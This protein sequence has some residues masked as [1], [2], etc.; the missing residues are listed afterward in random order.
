MDEYKK[1]DFNFGIAIY[2]P[3][4]VRT[5]AF[6]LTNEIESRVPLTFRLDE[7]HL[8]HITLFQG[9]FPAN[10]Q[11]HLEKTIQEYCSSL[12][13]TF[14]IE[15][16]SELFFHPIGNIFWNTTKPQHLKDAHLQAIELFRPLTQGALMQQWIERLDNPHTD[17]SAEQKSLVLKNGFAESGELF[18]PHITLGRLAEKSDSIKLQKMFISG[19]K[20]EVL[21]I[22]GGPLGTVGNIED[23]WFSHNI[24]V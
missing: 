24:S 1:G 4:D 20:F 10:A 13:E 23:I 12:R 15:L 6:S 21:E 2:P 22:I 19:E 8:P 3:I 14:E 5:K 16:M 11:A 18:L 9:A 7:I 17:L